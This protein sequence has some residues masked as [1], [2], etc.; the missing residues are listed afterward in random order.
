MTHRVV[1]LAQDG[2][3]PFELGIASRVFAAAD[4]DY[5][6]RVCTVSGEPVMTN[7]GFAISPEHG[8]EI[9]AEA[10]T[11][12]VA[13][14]EPTSLARHPAAD[15][16]RAIA[17]IRPGARIASICTGGFLLA[18][19]GLLDGRRAT[20]HWECAWLFRE[21]FPTVRLDDGVLFVDDGDVHTSAGAASG[22]DLCLHLIRADH[23]TAVAN[24]AARRCVV[25]PYREGGQAQF[26]ERPL[27][28]D[29]DASTSG[30][31][32]WA[33]ER[34]DEV[35]TVDRLAR[36]ALMSER[37]FVRRFTA[38]TGMPPRQWLTQQRLD[39][40]RALLEQTDLPIDEVAAAVG[41]AT[42]A[43]LR[44]HLG[45]RLGVTPVAYR[46]TFRERI[47]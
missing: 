38:E 27:L 8:P 37:T 15:T 12:I 41:Y 19:T 35:L 46:R 17:S 26:I 40:A 24:L 7:A 22:I 18:A 1:V 4:A 44:H 3:Y 25:A 23:G 5:E 32:A 29:A 28:D 6:V 14:V 42:A 45:A 30:T 33:L 13:P 31:R 34:L 9:L 36:H 39:A 16:V 47:A 21:W 10:D 11:V 43:S 2:V 20:T